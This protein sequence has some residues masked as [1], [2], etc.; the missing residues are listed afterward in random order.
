M[1]HQM[2]KRRYPGLQTVSADVRSLP[3]RAESFDGIVSN[4]TLDHFES[5]EDLSS[6]LKELRR[7]LRP[8]GQLI[9]TLDNPINPVVFLR[10]RLPSGLLRKIGAV[11]YYVGRTLGTRRLKRLLKELGFQLLETDVILHCPRILA[12]I[13]AGWME[14]HA[15]R[16]TQ[17][18]FLSLLMSFEKMSKLPTRFLTG[19][20]VAVRCSR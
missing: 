7:V 1:V 13:L 10:N 3:F 6:A 16:E 15:S 14:K 4:S 11:P 17:R 8:G 2:A 12:V 5:M 20:F 9:L 19:Y 18:K